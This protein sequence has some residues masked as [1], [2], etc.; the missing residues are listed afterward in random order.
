MRLKR[1]LQRE[2]RDLGIEV[3]GTVPDLTRRLEDYWRGQESSSDD[4]DDPK[5]VCEAILCTESKYG[6]DEYTKQKAKKAF[7]LILREED[8]IEVANVRGQV[9]VGNR[10]GLD[11]AGHSERLR[12][13]EERDAQK[14]NQIASLNEK[15]KSLEESNALS[16]KY[17]LK[18]H[19]QMAILKESC[20]DY[21]R[22]RNRFI[23]VFA[24]DVLD[25]WT[26]A[27]KKIIDDGNRKAHDGDIS[28]DALLYQGREKREDGWVF[29]ELYGIHYAEAAKISE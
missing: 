25:V 27:N 22:I 28:T 12:I 16:E 4:E 21:K 18:I 20:Q 7:R 26:P 1:D 8:S 19:D 17:N 10:R 6:T 11:L 24:R 23:S 2:C 15:V 9:A 13:L 14:T 29:E 5:P 3:G